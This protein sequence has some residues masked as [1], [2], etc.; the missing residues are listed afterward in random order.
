MLVESQVLMTMQVPLSRPRQPTD[1]QSTSPSQ[2]FDQQ[3]GLESRPDSLRS[4][5][6]L[7]GRA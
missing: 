6:D 2:G 5:Q 4:W 3:Y 7:L 1:R